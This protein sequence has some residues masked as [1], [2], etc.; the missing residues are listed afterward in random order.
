MQYNWTH[1]RGGKAELETVLPSIS[2]SA[3]AAPGGLADR[4]A[5]VCGVFYGVS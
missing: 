3:A 5:V 1:R 4:L 2:A